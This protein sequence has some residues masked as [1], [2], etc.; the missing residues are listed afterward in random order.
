MTSDV[1]VGLELVSDSAIQKWRD[2]LGPT[3]TQNAK[4]QAP[5]SLRAQFGTDGTRNAAHGSD[6]GPSAKRELDFFF[7]SGRMKT[8]ALMNNCTVAIIKPHAVKDGLAG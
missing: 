6:S 8:T 5:S 7:N 4:S 1:V 2:T 3:N